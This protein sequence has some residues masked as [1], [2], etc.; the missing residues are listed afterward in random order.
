MK[1]E[2]LPVSTI[3]ISLVTK[4][5]SLKIV[6]CH[7]VSSW[8]TV[9][10]ETCK[11]KLIMLKRLLALPR[12]RMFGPY[13]T[14]WFWVWKLCMTRILFIE[15]SSVLMCF[16]PKMEWLNS[17]IWMY[18][19]LRKPGFWKHKQGLRIMPVL[20]SGR[21]NLTITSLIYGLL[22]RYCTSS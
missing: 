16:W 12:S 5:P 6:P 21:I 3:P 11:P 20:K 10:M 2:Y 19:K 4:K 8:S 13:F 14:R 1:S 9:T 22:E 17:V 18:R 7:C 15:I